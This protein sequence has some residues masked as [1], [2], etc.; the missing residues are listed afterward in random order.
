MA[1]HKPTRI[2]GS[3]GGRGKLA[4]VASRSRGGSVGPCPR[5]RRAQ[6]T[7]GSPG[8]LTQWPRDRTT[9]YVPFGAPSSRERLTDF[10]DGESLT[11]Y[12]GAKGYLR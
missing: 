9:R 11:T 1:G 5:L 12:E 3:A 10:I 2:P 7:Q 6:A 8:Q 4:S